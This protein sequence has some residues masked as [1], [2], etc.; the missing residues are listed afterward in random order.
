MNDPYGKVM[1]RAQIRELD[2]RAIQEYG[3][4]GMV[5]MENAG[6]SVVD[7]LEQLGID[8]P[9]AICCGKGNNGGDGL[10]MARHLQERGREVDVWASSPLDQWR[11][12][13]AANLKICKASGIE[14]RVA[15]VAHAA[16]LADLVAALQGADWIVDALLG[17]GVVGAVR[18]PVRQILEVINTIDAKKLAVD[19]PSGLDCDT[20]LPQGPVF[21]ADYTCTLVA[22]KPGL[23]V[24]EAKPFVGEL[25]IGSIGAPRALVQAMLDSLPPQG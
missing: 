25:H 15:N 17:T 20:G 1:T 19:M 6:R 24:P 14:V 13:A 21:Q 7:L 5:L 12:D 3:V 2:R 10:V 4:P 11:G 8:G 16:G 22:P 9:V 18:S 23:L